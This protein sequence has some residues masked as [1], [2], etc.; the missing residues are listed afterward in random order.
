MAVINSTGP[1]AHHTVRMY[2]CVC[3]CD[4]LC[5]CIWGVVHACMCV[6]VI[7]YV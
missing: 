3:V 4:F 5:V 1:P 6:R 2:V 7:M